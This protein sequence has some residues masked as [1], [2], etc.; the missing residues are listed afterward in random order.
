MNKILY[1]V[2]GL[3]F[4][5]STL[6]A[7]NLKDSTYNSKISAPGTK[8][9]AVYNGK[10]KVFTQKIGN[11][12]VNLLLLHGGPENTH[13]YF[14][15]FPEHLKQA[16]VTIYFYDQLGSYFSDTPDDSTIWNIVR[17]VEEVEEVR[18]GLNIDHFYLLGHSW[19]GMLAELYAAR[20]GQHL[21]GLILSNVPGFFSNDPKYLR[22]VIDSIDKVVQ[23]RATLLSQFTNNKAQVDSLSRGLKLA[24]TTVHKAL[25]RQYNKAADSLFIRTMYYNKGGK[26][27]EPLVRNFK[28]VRFESIEK[29]NFN[30]FDANYQEA[31]KKINTPTLLIGG[32]NDFVLPVGYD[33]MKKMMTKAKVRVYICPTGAHFTMWDDT[34]NYFKELSRFIY[35]VERGNFKLDK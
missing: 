10:Y 14:E 8:M 3:L 29:Y 13:E 32:K 9:I 21:K 22:A 6:Q 31:L 18:K 34:E 2:T 5:L 33:V 17:L 4:L 35:E 25:A 23:H 16:G 15:N 20:Y 12:K 24:D 30:P 26:I 7:Q 19:G 28:H 11:G 27:P 1:L